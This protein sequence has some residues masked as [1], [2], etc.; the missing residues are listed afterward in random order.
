MSPARTRRPPPGHGTGGLD[1]SFQAVGSARCRRR[2]TRYDSALHGVT[3]NRA[4]E[5]MSARRARE[6]RLQMSKPLKVPSTGRGDGC[7][8]SRFNSSRLLHRSGRGAVASA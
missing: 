4:D 1:G 5:S 2:C 8:R 6:S 7:V 3:M